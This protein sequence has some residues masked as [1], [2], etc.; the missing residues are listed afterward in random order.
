M[1]SPAFLP[2][3]VDEFWHCHREENSR[4]STKTNWH[5]FLY[6]LANVALIFVQLLMLLVQQ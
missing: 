6:A 5:P 1:F 2:V 4:I 3:H